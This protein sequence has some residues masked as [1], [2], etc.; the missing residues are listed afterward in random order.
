MKLGW[1]WWGH[2]EQSGGI[3]SYVQVDIELFFKDLKMCFLLTTLNFLKDCYHF[4]S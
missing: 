2:W 3:Q 1:K 4:L